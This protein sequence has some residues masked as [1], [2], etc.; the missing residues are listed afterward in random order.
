MTEEFGEGLLDGANANGAAAPDVF[1]NEA[2]TLF[3]GLPE[4]I[5]RDGF[6]DYVLGLQTKADEA[7]TKLGQYESQLAQQ[8][9]AGQGQ[10]QPEPNAPQADNAAA[11]AV[12]NAAQAAGASK[13][14]AKRVYEAAAQMDPMLQ[15]YIGNNYSTLD[16]N[17]MYQPT[18]GYRLQPAVLKACQAMNASL[19]HQRRILQD[20]TRDPYTATNEFVQHSPWA[21]QMQERYDALQAKLEAQQKTFEERLT[22]LQAQSQ[23]Q[24]LQQLVND[25]HSILVKPQVAGKP[26]EWSPAG[27]MFNRMV[28]GD[29]AAGIPKTDP[30]VALVYIKQMQSAFAPPPAAKKPPKQQTPI[31]A[32]T[33][34]ITN[35]PALVQEMNGHR[36]GEGTQQFRQ[37]LRDLPPPIGGDE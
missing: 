17:G 29:P 10:G 21:Q 14:Q 12:A 27:E 19:D 20:F 36:P 22:P 18:E 33:R 3:E 25:N 5:S 28:N 26:P 11:A 4:D 35:S 9:V 6:R 32:L 16:A 1:L 31:A 23:E 8:M 2:R 37:R 24:A 15:P 30:Q 13:S 7:A 34:R